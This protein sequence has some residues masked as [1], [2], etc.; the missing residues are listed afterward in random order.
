MVTGLLEVYR[1]A[2]PIHMM[3]LLN[4]L[5]LNSD[6]LTDRDKVE[7]GQLH[8]LLAEIARQRDNDL[9]ETVQLLKIPA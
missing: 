1:H 5:T 6:H 2:D 7:I 4:Q 9:T 8:H 3:E